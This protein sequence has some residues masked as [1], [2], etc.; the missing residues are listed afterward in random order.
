MSIFFQA[1]KCAG[2]YRLTIDTVFGVMSVS[3]ADRKRRFRAVSR[4]RSIL[5]AL[6]FFGVVLYCINLFKNDALDL[7]RFA[8]TGKWG[9]TDQS[10]VYHSVDY[11]EPDYKLVQQKGQYHVLLP[12]DG[13]HAYHEWQARVFYYWYKRIKES[14]SPKAMGGLTRLLHSGVPDDWMQEIPTV[15]VDPLPRDLERIADGHVMLRRP[16]A[17]Q[18]WVKHYMGKIPE[19]FVLLTEPDHVFIRAPPLWATYNRPSA[20]PMG[21]MDVKNPEHRAIF[22][23]FN[24]KNVPVK[25]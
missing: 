13:A 8:D 9:A 4:K 12:C 20:Y 17:V 23:K 15:V 5:V 2:S 21:F 18:Q 19:H 22:E 3:S 6:P 1:L 24:A 16:Y 25:V 14:K 11:L 7:Y 10:S